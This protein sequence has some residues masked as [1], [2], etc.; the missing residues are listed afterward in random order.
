MSKYRAEPAFKGM[1]LA[2]EDNTKDRCPTFE[3]F[4]EKQRLKKMK[5]KRRKGR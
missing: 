2:K 4:K 5:K 1:K 3:Q